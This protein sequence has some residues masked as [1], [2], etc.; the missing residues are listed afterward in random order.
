MTYVVCAALPNHD[1]LDCLDGPA[2][3]T[4]VRNIP[5]N[6]RTKILGDNYMSKL[7]GF[8]A[9]IEKLS[10]P[11]N[12]KI[13]RGKTDAKKVDTKNLKIVDSGGSNMCVYD[14]DGI[15]PM[16]VTDATM[17][18]GSFTVFPYI[19]VIGPGQ[20]AGVD[21]TFDP[22][23]CETAKEKLRFVVCGSDES[24]SSNQTIAV[25]VGG[26]GGGGGVFDIAGDSC[27]PCIITED[28]SSIFEEIEV[29]SSLAS[30]VESCTGTGM[31]SG[32]EI[33][34]GMGSRDDEKHSRVPV[35]KVIFAEKENI[36]VW[37]AVMCGAGDTR[38][39][40][41]R[42]RI[43]NPTKIDTKVKFRILTTEEAAE[44]TS[45]TLNV[46][47]TGKEKDIKTLKKEA[48]SSKVTVI[49]VAVES[50]FTVQ[51]EV[52][53]IPPH[54]HRYVTV[55]FN[56]VEIKN[57]RA[58]FT[59]D[60][61][62]CSTLTATST[63]TSTSTAVLRRKA[64][65]GSGT[66]LIFDV[67]GSGT[68]PCISIEEPTQRQS[69]G[70]LLLDFQKVHVDR[71]CYRRISIKNRGVMPATCLFEMTGSDDFKFSGRNSSL[72][73]E[74]GQQENLTVSYCPKSVGDSKDVQ[75]ASVRVTVL[76]NHFDFYLLKL[77]GSAYECDA[78]IDTD[79]TDTDTDTDKDYRALTVYNSNSNSNSNVRMDN[80]ESKGSDFNYDKSH[81][82]F[83]FP[84]I[85][86]AESPG[87]VSSTTRTLTLRSRSPHTLKY[88]FSLPDGKLYSYLFI[89]LHH[90]FHSVLF[91]SS[92]YFISIP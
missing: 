76:K 57:Y 22:S 23:G 37:G 84:E 70:S 28:T 82:Y 53:D 49:P 86:L 6:H 19:G 8:G 52:W 83:I 24:D 11:P 41:Q 17:R 63:S 34:A 1:E 85:N 72:T 10:G 91:C 38:G 75:T 71:I 79:T 7:T 67:G 15:A 42:V 40:A 5:Y 74:P 80:R 81:E 58:V 46:K 66:S 3:V 78:I 89:T 35:G 73:L 87:C 54:E 65:A 60:V 92:R 56:P 77:K 43:T 26:G 14:P 62:D 13:I 45:S 9:K 47:V 32:L 59:A 36:M 55:Y 50:A 27:Y 48:K 69:D 29:I 30:L 61:A 16:A 68:M 88:E 90:H 2:Y 4:V 44:G 21:I 25:A 51:P 64:A 39:V 33:G 12:S 31:G 18:V 20:I